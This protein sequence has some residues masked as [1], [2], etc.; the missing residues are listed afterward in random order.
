MIDEFLS[1]IMQKLNTVMTVYYEE[2]PSS[3]EF[4]YGVVPTLTAVPLD[5]GF[6]CLFDVELYTNEISD[7]NIEKMCDDLRTALDGYNYKNSVI[8]FHVG[9]DSQFLIKQTEQDLTY[10]R[11]SFIAR[12]F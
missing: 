12:I 11:I 6:Q 5:Y 2:A 9:F 8:G 3:A 1:I 10:R 7:T 4:P